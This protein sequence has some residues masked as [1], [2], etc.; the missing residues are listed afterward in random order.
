MFLSNR[1]RRCDCAVP[2]KA[3]PSARNPFI[4][5][6]KSLRSSVNPFPLLASGEMGTAASCLLTLSLWPAA[7]PSLLS[8][9]HCEPPTLDE[10]LTNWTVG[11]P[12]WLS[13]PNTF[14]IFSFC[15]ASRNL[16]DPNTKAPRPEKYL[17][18][19]P[20][21]FMW[22]QAG[23]GGQSDTMRAETNICCCYSNCI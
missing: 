16:G 9:P 15:Y 21:S 12:S 20:V 4:C 8:A 1:S 17:T 7:G 18:G 22:P 3:L 23:G 19:L 14:S 10:F 5:Q 13:F 2:E 6:S 11:F